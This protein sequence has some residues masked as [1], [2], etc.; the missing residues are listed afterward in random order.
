MSSETGNQ[1]S[2]VVAPDTTN[3]DKLAKSVD[4][5]KAELSGPADAAAKKSATGGSAPVSGNEGDKPDGDEADTKKSPASNRSPGKK[6]PGGR[7]SSAHR[8]ATASALADPQSLLDASSIDE[9]TKQTQCSIPYQRSTFLVVSGSAEEEAKKQ[10]TK[11]SLRSDVWNHM[12]TSNVAAFPRPVYRR[13]PNF[14]DAAL[15]CNSVADLPQFKAAQVLLIGPDR[16]QQHIRF[17]ALEQGKTLLVPTSRL[18]SGMFNKIVPPEDATKDQLNLCAA[19]E[20]VKRFSTPVPLDEKVKIDLVIMGSV[21]VSSTGR[22]LGKGEGFADLEWAMMRSIEA[23]DKDTVVITCVHDCQVKENLPSE[24]FSELDLTVDIIVTP[25]QTLPV[26]EP[27]PKPNGLVWSK[28]T[29]EKLEKCP[30]LKNLRQREEAAGVNVTLGESIKREIISRVDPENEVDKCIQTIG[31]SRRRTRSTTAN[32][33]RSNRNGKDV[34]SKHVAK[35]KGIRR[36]RKE[37][38]REKS[39]GEEEDTGKESS[40]EI[41]KKVKQRRNKLRQRS[42]KGRKDSTKENDPERE[43][44]EDSGR[45]DTSADEKPTRKR[46]SRKTDKAAAEGGRGDAGEQRQQ[47]GRRG[48]GGRNNFPP[49]P[50]Q[51]FAPPWLHPYNAPPPPPNRYGGYY[52]PPPQGGGGRYMYRN[53]PPM[54]DFGYEDT[55]FYGPPGRRNPPPGAFYPTRR[56]AVFVGDIPKDCGEDMFNDM[57]LDRKVKPYRMIWQ[58]DEARTFLVFDNLQLAKD[59]LRKLR[60][61]SIN[62]EPCRVDLSNMTKRTYFQ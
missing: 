6:S 34:Q 40:G 18:E 41:A 38:R 49:P 33:G 44:A 9:V 59:C 60:N 52:P 45:G 24:I 7:N 15:A 23:V 8:A 4:A 27:L 28:L 56:P 54:D 37:R 30:V 35:V 21:V 11:A 46:G 32:G 29:P 25:T 36:E 58:E 12:E 51:R 17:L 3:P 14:K 5:S 22:R 48:R 42:L 1:P 39:T 19:A 57:L 62:D 53:Q 20:G 13:I 50:P 43:N 47:S 55:G 16:P 10:P 26:R 31:G 61:L 2:P